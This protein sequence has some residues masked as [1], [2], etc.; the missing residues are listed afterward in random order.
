MPPWGPPTP[1]STVDAKAALYRRAVGFLNLVEDRSSTKTFRWSWGTALLNE[2]Y[3][4]KWD[5]NFLRLEDTPA[6]TEVPAVIDEANRIFAEAGLVHRNLHRDDDSGAILVPAFRAAGWD[7]EDLLVMAQRGVLPDLEGAQVDEIGPEAI[8]RPTEH[9]YKD[10]LI[11][12]ESALE[13]LTSSIAATEAAVSVRYFAVHD[14]AGNVVSWCH[15]YQEGDVAQ[16][17]EVST[18]PRFRNRGLAAAVVTRAIRAARDAG[19][20]LVF[21][22]ADAHDWPKDLYGKLGFESTGHIFEFRRNPDVT[23]ATG[24][25]P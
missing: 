16:I 20:E 5:L 2:S 6:P 1:P 21:L 10:T 12:T 14:P 7:A 8:R 25:K 4:V 18:F 24:T 15:L 17:E 23:R 11:L 13:N 19:A 3:P 22:V 9:W